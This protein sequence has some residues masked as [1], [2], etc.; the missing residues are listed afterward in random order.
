MTTAKC[1]WEVTAG[2]IPGEADPTYHR[3][4]AMNST[5][6]E[7]EQGL[8]LYLERGQAARAYTQYLELQCSQGRMV[9]WIRLDFIWY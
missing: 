7:S 8:L 2:I 1:A 6:W 9:N 3:V 5:E 4:W